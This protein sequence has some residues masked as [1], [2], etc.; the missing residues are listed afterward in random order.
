[1]DNII[2]KEKAD[3]ESQNFEIIE[4]KEISIKEIIEIDEHFERIQKQN[5][6]LIKNIKSPPRNYRCL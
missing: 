6:E 5:S 1:L 3:S 2:Q 4:L